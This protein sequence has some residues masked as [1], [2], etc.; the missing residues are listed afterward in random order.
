MTP[1]SENMRLKYAVEGCYNGVWGDD[2]NGQD[3]LIV[4]RVADFD[5]DRCVVALAD[6]PTVRAV[7]E[8]ARNRRVLRKG[9]LLIEKSGGGE[10]QPVGNVV[11]FNED[12]DAVCSNFV[13]RMPVLAECDSRYVAYVFRALYAEG[14]NIPHVKQTSGIQNLDSASYLNER[15]WLPMRRVQERIANFLDEKTARIDALIA[16]KD[17]L[18]ERL[19]IY[20]AAVIEA[21]VTGQECEGPRVSTRF[22]FC[23]SIPDKWVM[24]RLKHISPDIV[25]G[26]VVNPSDYYCDDGRPFVFGGDISESGVR[27]ETTRRISESGNAVNP[28]SVLRTG[29]LLTVR[30][31]EPGTTA[32]VPPELDGANC[33]SVMLTRGSADFNS[34][35]L[36]ACMNSTIGKSQVSMVA[37][38]AAMKQFNIS[39]AR[40]FWFP[41]PPQETQA[42]IALRAAGV[43]SRVALLSDH[44]ETH[45]ERLR[46]YRS[47][48]ISAAVTGELDVCASGRSRPHPAVA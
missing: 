45:I 7:A 31:G 11:L 48:L 15:V 32:V 5:R 43:S 34:H 29:D 21:L 23:P 28:K 35:W 8:S 17:R 22:E 27:V 30:V 4:V 37:Y 1:R 24:R 38:G 42:G 39:H 46:E 33:A 41:V 44:V 12:V 47:S 9:D 3:D 36:A 40:E 13:A 18:L 19:R 2:P 6:N 14:R 26:I 25:V 16:E 10:Q 20:R